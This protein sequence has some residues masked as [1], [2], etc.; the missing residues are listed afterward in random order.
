MQNYIQLKNAGL[1]A[2]VL[3]NGSPAIQKKQFDPVLGTLLEPIEEGIS[4][5]SLLQQQTSM[6]DQL[7]DLA[8][9]ITD[10]KAVVADPSASTPFTPRSASKAQVL[11]VLN[12]TPNGSGG[13]LYDTYLKYIET[14]PIP[15]QIAANIDTWSLDSPSLMVGMAAVGLTPEMAANLMASAAQIVV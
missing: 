14:A 2:V 3:V 9:Q 7:A 4:L 8:A 6:T 11:L 1:V 5:D 12:A 13:T 15:Q 10:V